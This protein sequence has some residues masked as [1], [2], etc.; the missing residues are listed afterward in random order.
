MP[1]MSFLLIFLDGKINY[2]VLP[3]NFLNVFMIGSTINCVIDAILDNSSL[4]FMVLFAVA[5][6]SQLIRV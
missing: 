4:S 3:A 1:K 6:K 5:A 2:H